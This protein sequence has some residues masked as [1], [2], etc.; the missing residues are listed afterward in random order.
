[1][2]DFLQSILLGS[3]TGLVGT[4]MSFGIDWFKTRQGHAQELKLRE[5][6]LKIAEMEAQG[7]VNAS[8]IEAEAESERAAA[9][10]LSASYRQE[11]TR[12]SR[13]G[14]TGI[15]LAVDVVRGFM[16]P[17]LT[18]GFLL[19]TGVIYFLLSSQVEYFSLRERIIDTILYLTVTCVIWWFGGRQLSK[20]Q[21]AR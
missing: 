19:L 1:M 18:A 2:F 9:S 3:G 15:M 7:A 10:A 13:P 6:D 14:E 17:G 16:R 12:F 5:M 4:A 20:T 11:M 21:A 8:L